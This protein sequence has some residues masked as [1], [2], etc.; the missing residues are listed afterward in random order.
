MNITVIYGQQHRG[1]TW[2]LTKLLDQFEGAAITEFF[3]PQSGHFIVP[4]ACV[5]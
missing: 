2:R 4:A 5:A 3:L 1:N